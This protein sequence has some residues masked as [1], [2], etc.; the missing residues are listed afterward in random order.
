M[1]YSIVGL[2]ILAVI[3]YLGLLAWRQ[4]EDEQCEKKLQTAKDRREEARREL[5]D[6]SQQNEEM[7]FWNSSFHDI[8]TGSK[9]GGRGIV[10]YFNWL[11][12][13]MI[14]AFTLAGGNFVAY[15]LSD[16]G[17]HK[18][19]SHKSCM[20]TDPIEAYDEVTVSTYMESEKWKVERHKRHRLLDGW[21]DWG[22]QVVEAVRKSVRVIAN[23]APPTGSVAE[24]YSQYHMRAFQASITSYIIVVAAIFAFT[25]FQLGWV[26]AR[27][28]NREPHA[29]SYTAVVTGLPPDLFHGKLL[30]AFF[31]RCPQK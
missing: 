12:F 31:Q 27:F 30:T 18:Q 23:E 7:D 1:F 2:L 24:R 13:G 28:A 6:P 9:R 4:P 16:L 17:R 22:H 29:R 14:V 10:L 19:Q 26:T 25:V 20:V 11:I 21:A 15:E 3:I 8:N 5:M